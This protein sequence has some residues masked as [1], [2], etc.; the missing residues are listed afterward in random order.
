MQF[1]PAA[2]G[3]E[4]QSIFALD[5]DGAR[6]LALAHPDC[7]SEAARARVLE[8]FVDRLPPATLAGIWVY[9]GCFE[10]AH[11]VVQDLESAEGS[12][13]HAI[14]HRQEPD[15]SNSRYWFSRV[16]QH[17]IF[18]ELQI[19]A[20]EV[21]AQYPDITFPLRREWDPSAF[22]DFCESAR[23]KPGS[24]EER[25]ARQIQLAEWQLLFDHCA[26]RKV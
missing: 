1:D 21:L 22:I 23:E 9:L 11:A 13:W 4:V 2:Y 17:P 16:G 15:A 10:E 7:S 14:L 20:T 5:G 24:T 8:T 19:A 3:D 25:V 6:I 18:T 26:R 12:Y